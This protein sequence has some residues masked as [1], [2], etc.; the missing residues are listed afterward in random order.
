MRRFWCELHFFE[1]NKTK[2]FDLLRITFFVNIQTCS[3]ENDSCQSPPLGDATRS[4]SGNSPG[5]RKAKAFA[6]EVWKRFR[7]KARVCDSQDES[8]AIDPFP[9]RLDGVIVL[10]ERDLLDG[11][12]LEPEIQRLAE[13]FNGSYAGT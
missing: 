12:Q 5:K 11:Q 10:V 6:A 2:R 1:K 7:L 3:S 8:N 9:Y 4:A 13:Q